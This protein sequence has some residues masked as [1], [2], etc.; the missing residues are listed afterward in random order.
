MKTKTN[1]TFIRNLRRLISVCGDMVF[2]WKFSLM[3]HRNTR[4]GKMECY[5][6]PKYLFR[7][8]KE[9]ERR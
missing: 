5:K 9:N 2:Q 7:F 6:G 3:T 4:E 1:Q 8:V